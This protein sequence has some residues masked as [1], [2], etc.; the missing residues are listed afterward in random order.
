MDEQQNVVTETLNEEPNAVVQMIYCGPTLPPEHGL[1]QFQ[2]FVGGLPTHVADLV[3]NYPVIKAL[4]VPVTE[5]AAT[6][7][8]LNQTGSAEASMYIEIQKMFRKGKGE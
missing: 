8:A 4:L 5:L 3:K 2:V 6:R 7:V 1:T